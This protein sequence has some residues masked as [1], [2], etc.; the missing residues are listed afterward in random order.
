MRKNSIERSISFIN[1]NKNTYL[2][3]LA[4]DYKIDRNLELMK[5]NLI[6]QDSFEK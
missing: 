6:R 2:K 4:S 1:E 5:K 3:K